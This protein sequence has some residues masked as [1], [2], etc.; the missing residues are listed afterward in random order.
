[1]KR[2]IVFLI[3]F[4]LFAPAAVA[5]AGPTETQC[6]ATVVDELV[7]VHDEYRSVVFGSRADRDG[8]FVALTGGKV[9][10]ERVGIFETKGRLGSELVEPLVEAYRAYRCR[11]LAVCSVLENSFNQKTAD[12]LLDIKI[13]GCVEQPDMR[14][15]DT[16]YLSPGTTDE[17]AG[18]GSDPRTALLLIS[19]CQD[20]VRQ[21]LSAEKSVL[22]LAMSYDA[23]YRALLQ[24]SGI[25]DWMLDGFPT[26]AVKAISE[27]VNMLGK[28]H[29][30]PC[31]IGQCDDPDSASLRP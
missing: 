14:R 29:Q 31:F 30:I 17:E 21:T 12:Q 19:Q 23:G 7:K 4:C 28:L 11:S 3:T 25:T 22:R 8:D 9:E 20:I 1:M 13:Q 10:E 2:C 5:Q 18:Q 24:F 15:Y 6:Y 26:Q 16:C 27:M